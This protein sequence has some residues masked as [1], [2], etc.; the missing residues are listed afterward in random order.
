MKNFEIPEYYLSPIIG[1]VKNIRK[2]N[3]PRKRD[4]T[5]TVLDFGP[6][7]FYIARHFGF[8]YGVENAIEISYKAISENPDKNIYLLSQMIHNPGVNDD[9]IAHGISFIQDTNGRQIIPWSEITKDDIVIIPAF[10]TTVEIEQKLKSIGIEV[11]RYNT[12]CPFVE[13][14][15]NR[16]Q[17]LGQED[18][19]VIIHGKKNHEET[20]ATFSHANTN[21]KSIIV[22]DIKEAQLLAK[23]ISG[24]LPFSEF[25]TTFKN[26]YSDDFNPEQDLKKI[27]VVNQ[28]TMLASETQEITDFLYNVMVNKYGNEN[29][30]NHFANT[31]DTLCYATNDNQTST[32][33]LLDV[34]ADMAIV[35][36][37][38]NSSNTTHLVEL[39]EQ[40]FK[41]FF[42]KDETEIGDDFSLNYFDIHSKLITKSNAHHT[43]LPERLIL[44]SG[45]SCPD[46][47]VDRVLQKILSFYKNTKPIDEV[48]N[49]LSY[50]N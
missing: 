41:T 48:L 15:W 40:K 20:R 21:A 7:K 45:A 37:G 5:P 46:A 38:Y 6:V 16:S 25:K 22:K 30:K 49:T 39:L 23:F 31:R 33:N 27:G 35:V 14:V 26:Y 36:G 32:Q 4:F 24:E 11:K 18:Y 10:G 17:K 1:K 29:I 8:C 19:T 42:I 34:N 13:K 2:L 44:T 3:D 28:T 9:L 12:T 47:T 50:E 43:K